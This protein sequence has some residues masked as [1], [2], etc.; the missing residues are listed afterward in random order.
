MV[1]AAH[2]ELHALW[3]ALARSVR[4]YRDDPTWAASHVRDYRRKISTTIGL[5]RTRWWDSPCY[6]WLAD[7]FAAVVPANVQ[8][9]HPMSALRALVAARQAQRAAAEQD[10]V[11]DVK[12]R[13]ID[14][15][16]WAEE[17]KRRHR[18]EHYDPFEA[19]R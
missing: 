19:S 7:Q 18:I 9:A 12:N 14:D 11:T 8:A 10:W 1:A 2:T 17:L 13:P 15:A 4:G 3:K 5:C 6:Q 16:A